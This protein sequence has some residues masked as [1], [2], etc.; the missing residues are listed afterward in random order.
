MTPSGWH[1]GTTN[2]R[3]LHG[4][5]GAVEGRAERGEADEH[6][7]L[8]VFLHGVAH[9][10]IDRQQDLLMAPVELLLVVPTGTHRQSQR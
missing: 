4:L 9:V 5:H 7:H 8:R 10:L 2:L 6:V 1:G 3:V